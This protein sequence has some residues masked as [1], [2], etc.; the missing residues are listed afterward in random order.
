MANNNNEVKTGW[1]TAL[2]R[3][4]VGA[5]L[6]LSVSGLLITFSPFAAW[7]EWNVL[8]HTVIGL[9]AFVPIIWY[10]LAHWDDYKKYN[11]SDALLLGYVSALAFLVCVLSGLVVTWQG[12]FGIRMSPL[13]RNVHL[14]ST[15]VALGTGLVHVV[16]VWFRSRTKEEKP[17]A[18]NLAGWSLLGTVGGVLL[19][20]AV[21]AVSPRVS[22]RGPYHRRPSM[23]RRLGD[24]RARIGLSV[25][26]PSLR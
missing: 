11:L 5:L 3:L 9:L 17:R 13:W 2:T 16:I 7:V 15:F 6:Y 24:R 8:A 1:S 12:L 19:A 20:V 14:Y 10:S 4:G 26:V 18:G 22:E 21:P 25:W 23:H